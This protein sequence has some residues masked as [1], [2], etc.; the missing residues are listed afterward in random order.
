MEK[1]NFRVS[2]GEVSVCFLPAWVIELIVS[3]LTG[4]ELSQFML[5]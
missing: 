2:G 4:T 1:T 5:S 3:G